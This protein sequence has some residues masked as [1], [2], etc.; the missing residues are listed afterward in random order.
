MRK[1]YQHIDDE[2]ALSKPQL[3]NVLP[4]LLF[5]PSRETSASLF[6]SEALSVEYRLSVPYIKSRRDRE[7]LESQSS[8]LS[9]STSISLLDS[10]SEDSEPEPS[11]KS[12]SAESLAVFEQDAHLH[13]RRETFGC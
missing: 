5:C 4:N 10:G 8:S 6:P 12:E 2:L 3:G 11:V 13:F 7:T 9:I 1:K